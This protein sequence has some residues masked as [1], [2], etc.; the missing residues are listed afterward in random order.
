MA[1]FRCS[2]CD[3]NGEFVYD[4]TRH[5]CPVCGSND[6]VFAL[7]IDELTDEVFASAG[8]HDSDECDGE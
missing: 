6:V 5:V 2:A 7:A 1:R 8:P 3:R 4:P